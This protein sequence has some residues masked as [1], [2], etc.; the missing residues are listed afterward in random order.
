MI[1]R[2]LFIGTSFLGAIKMG[3]ELKFPDRQDTFI[4]FS[5]PKLAAS[6]HK[7]VSVHDSYLLIRNLE[8]LTSIP[9]QSSSQAVRTFKDVSVVQN[10]D[11]DLRQFKF[12]VFTHFYFSISNQII[13]DEKSQS[14]VCSQIPVSR[15][16]LNQ[17]RI[18]GFNGYR[19]IS[20]QDNL[21]GVNTTEFIFNIRS[22]LKDTRI[23]ILPS[24]R[25]PQGYIDVKKKYGDV[26]SAIRTQDFVDKYYSEK[27]AARGIEYYAQPRSTLDSDACFTDA[28][29][30]RGMI[31]KGKSTKLDIHMNR[32]FGAIVANDLMSR[33]ETENSEVT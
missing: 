1:G 20:G 4:G 29:F 11:I 21:D 6:F 8:T 13:I 3:W 7:S 31:K 26:A 10:L 32:E 25:R 17:M 14:I 15:S 23:I 28:R 12:I 24:P 18:N 33:L 2:G 9:G 19:C 27:F 16:M 22:K 30:S 5:A